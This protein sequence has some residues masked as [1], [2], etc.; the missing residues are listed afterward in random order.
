MLDKQIFEVD[1]VVQGLD[2]DDD[3]Q[4]TRIFDMFGDDVQVSGSP[5]DGTIHLLL[6]TNDPIAETCAAIARL[7]S[8]LPQI[9]VLRIDSGLVAIPDI[10]RRIGRSRENIRQFADGTRG[11]GGFPTPDGVVGDGIRVWRWANV[12]LWLRNNV[13]C[14]FPTVPIPS[15]MVDAINA[16]LGTAGRIVGMV[17]KDT[18]RGV[19]H[20]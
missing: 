5:E 3:S 19:S 9:E 1:L 15:E 20:Y 11:P 13:A 7:N 12:E 14:E 10:A 18:R 16:S 4:I 8:S 6:D 17:A 2:L